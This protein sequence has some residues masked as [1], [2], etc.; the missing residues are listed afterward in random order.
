M[1]RGARERQRARRTLRVGL[2]VG[3]TFAAT[4]ALSSSSIGDEGDGRESLDSLVS[5]TIASRFS[6][7]L[8]GS[9]TSLLGTG[10]MLTERLAKESELLFVVSFRHDDFLFPLEADVALLGVG[11]ALL[12]LGCVAA[13]EKKPKILCCFPVDEG[14]LAGVDFSP[15]LAGFGHQLI[16]QLDT[17]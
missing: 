5:R 3:S 7:E 11:V 12:D 10:V 6:W 8:R 16:N 15:M 9:T 13:F 4:A 2:L 17:K 14:V 1:H